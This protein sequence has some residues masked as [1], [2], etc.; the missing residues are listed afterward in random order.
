MFKHVLSPAFIIA[1]I[2][3]CKKNIIPE[4]HYLLD[5]SGF[6]KVVKTWNGGNRLKILMFGWEFPPY[7]I[8]GLGRV[9][10][11]LVKNLSNRNV[12]IIFVTAKGKPDSSSAKVISMEDEN[13]KLCRVDSPVSCYMTPEG[14]IKVVSGSNIHGLYGH[15]LFEEVENYTKKAAELVAEEYYDIIHAHDWMTFG[16]G[17]EAKKQSG[18]PLVVHVHSTEFDRVGDN[19][20]QRVYSIEKKGMQAA[21]SVIAVSNYTKEK[22]VQ[23]YGINPDKIAVVY[24]ATDFKN[25]PAENHEIKSS[26][27]VLFLGRVTFQKGPEYFLHAAK[28]VLEHE[29]NVKFVVA[30]SGDM[31]PYIIDKAV[32]LKIADKVLFTGFLDENELNRIYRLADVYVLPSVSEPFGITV[33]EAMKSGVPVIVSKNSG[34][35]ELVKHCLTTDF[36]DINEMSDKILALLNHDVLHSTLKM[37]GLREASSITWGS[38]ADK[39]LEVYNKLGVC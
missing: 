21:D 34:V 8:G 14:Y 33:L 39:C 1:Y 16:A 31:E 24:N 19:V 37:N 7:C 26:K 5:I 35:R 12:K 20:N 13:I 27:L 38:A 9:C 18:K 30:G 28:K 22:I 36:W 4:K 3:L 25:A 17:I 29:K 23:N 2:L 15:N 32:E 11:N 6:G 10:S